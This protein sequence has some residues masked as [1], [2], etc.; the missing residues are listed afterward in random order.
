MH[1][2][3]LGDPW[4]FPQFSHLRVLDIKISCIVIP[5]STEDV[6]RAFHSILASLTSPALEHVRL[7]LR[8]SIATTLPIQDMD[9]IDATTDA[10]RA[11]YSN[12]HA[13]LARPI[14]SSLRRVTVVLS[15]TIYRD[16]KDVAL[17]WLDFLRALF[18]PWCVRG[19]VNLACV[20]DS[21]SGFVDT[22]AADKG[23]GPHF[24]ELRDRGYDLEAALQFVGLDPGL[25]WL[26]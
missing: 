19:I 10:Y 24:I 15:P 16:A 11:Q 25:R 14:F 7:E 22:I 6:Q 4:G 8:G 26:G 17:K 21:I 13:V 1:V 5:I 18:A 12:L 23:E 20:A 2:A 3:G 9:P